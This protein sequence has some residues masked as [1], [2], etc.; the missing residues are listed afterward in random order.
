MNRN[1]AFAGHKFRR[2]RPEVFRGEK[3]IRAQDLA[4]RKRC[5][6]AVRRVLLVAVSV[7]GIALP[8]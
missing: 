4:H 6:S 7:M 2:T 8:G 1:T 3:G 5:S